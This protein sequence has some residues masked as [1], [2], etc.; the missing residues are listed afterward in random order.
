[1]RAPVRRIF[2]FAV[3]QLLLLAACGGGSGN[4]LLSGGG[5]GGGGGGNTITPLGPGNV[6]AMSVDPGPTGAN[7]GIFNIPYVKVTVCAHGSTT[8]CQTI[9]HVEVDTGSYGLRIISSVM[10]SAVL[11]GLTQEQSIVGGALVECTQFGDGIAWG[12][13]RTADIT[14]SGETASNIPIQIIGDPNYPTIPS[15]CTVHGAPE[16]TVALFGA[17]GILGVGPFVQDCGTGCVGSTQNNVYFSCPSGG[18]ACTDVDTPLNLQTANPVAS[19]TTDNNGVILEMPSVADAGAVTASGVLVF[20]IGTQSNN[21]LGNAVVLTTDSLGYITTTFNNV[22][23][24]DAFI[25]SG[26]NL[27]F[28]VDSGVATCGTSP[29]QVFCP[30]SE[31]NVSATNMG[32]NG[33]QSTVSFK[34]GDATTLFNA[35][36]TYTAFNN[37]AAPNP[38]SKGFDFGMPFFYGRNVFTA[39]EGMN[40]SGGMGP[41]FAY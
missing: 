32:A 31:L 3:T 38:D 9:D 28:I 22:Q 27:N 10:N 39:I 25:D 37:V 8:N 16:N 34:I 12:S 24:I 23:Y 21:G 33:V 40:T 2:V 26:S 36:P 20:G 41:Y 35:N 19:F 14:V 13:M 17:N 15:N 1:M 29:N 7:T 11:A 6:V 30:S 5:G 18:G 4:G